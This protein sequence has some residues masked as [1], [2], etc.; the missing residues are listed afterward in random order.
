M[1]KFSVVIAH[2][3]ATSISLEEEFYDALVAL[4]KEQNIPLNAL[5]TQIDNTRTNENLSSAL[6]VYI[7]K[8]LQQKLK[9]D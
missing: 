8:S 4:A 2:R 6:R 1:K 9:A 5:I 3:H 7:L